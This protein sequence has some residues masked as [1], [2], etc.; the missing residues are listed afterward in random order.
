MHPFPF[1]TQWGMYT[2]EAPCPSDQEGYAIERPEKRVISL[3][4]PFPW[5]QERMGIYV[6]STAHQVAAAVHWMRKCRGE[7]DVEMMLADVDRAADRMWRSVMRIENL[8]DLGLAFHGFVPAGE[9]GP[10]N[11]SDF[12][13]AAEFW[14]GLLGSSC[15]EETMCELLAPILGVA[16]VVKIGDSGIRFYSGW[17][18]NML[19]NRTADFRELLCHQLQTRDSELK[20]N[21]NGTHDLEVVGRSPTTNFKYFKDPGKDAEL[22]ERFLVVLTEGLGYYNDGRPEIPQ[23]GVITVMLVGRAWVYDNGEVKDYRGWKSIIVNNHVMRN[24]DK[25]DTTRGKTS[26]LYEVGYTRDDVEPL[27]ERFISRMGMLCSERFYRGLLAKTNHLADY[28]RVPLSSDRVSTWTQRYSKEGHFRL[29]YPRLYGV[30]TMLADDER[31]A[32]FGM[33]RRLAPSAEKL[34]HDLRHRD[35]R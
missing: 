3:P 22:S 9:W 15:V 8:I 29:S 17:I 21:Y 20:A 27:V 24:P 12:R 31:D 33:I 13:S 4:L 25:S 18:V 16:G 6:A 34:S 2:H 23:H 19:V 10:I 1:P 28:L 7:A 26:L 32:F 30:T 35:D 14:M 5:F 11:R